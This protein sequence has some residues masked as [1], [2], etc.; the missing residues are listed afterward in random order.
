MRFDARELGETGLAGIGFIRIDGPDTNALSRSC[1][2]LIDRLHRYQST[3]PQD[4]NTISEIFEF[5]H[6]VTGQ[7]YR[8]SIVHCVMDERGEF[9]LE[10]GV[11]PGCRL[12]E[13]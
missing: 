1:T 11:E 5:G 8:G 3:I 4:G 12:V 9:P 2:Q 13:Q 10:Q 7:K 6:H